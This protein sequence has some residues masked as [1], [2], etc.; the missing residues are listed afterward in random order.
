MIKK[1]DDTILFMFKYQY[2]NAFEIGLTL[3][4]SDVIPIYIQD[5]F[6]NEIYTSLEIVI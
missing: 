1:I 4:K 5:I 2:M 3:N 6:V